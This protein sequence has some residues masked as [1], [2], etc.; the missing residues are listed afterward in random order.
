MRFQGYYIMYAKYYFVFLLVHF[1]ALNH[2]RREPNSLVQGKTFV[3]VLKN[4]YIYVY[5]CQECMII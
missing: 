5:E 4:I 2:L 3:F 1:E